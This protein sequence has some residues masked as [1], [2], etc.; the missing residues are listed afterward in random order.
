MMPIEQKQVAHLR[1]D[2]DIELLLKKL[3]SHDRTIT[4]NAQP[5]TGLGPPGSV[6]A[7]A[8]W[9]AQERLKARRGQASQRDR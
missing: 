4:T 6:E 5:G 1:F 8:V 9:A 7:L 3:A 2:S